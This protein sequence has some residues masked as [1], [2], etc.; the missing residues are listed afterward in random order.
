VNKGK[1]KKQLA[2]RWA[3]RPDAEAS[4]GL[5]DALVVP[6]DPV[7]LA[8]LGP[9]LPMLLLVYLSRGELRRD[10]LVLLEVGIPDVAARRP[11]R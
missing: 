2:L 10:L 11:A 3:L 9:R 1:N 8:Q 6:G 5:R 7:A 4:S